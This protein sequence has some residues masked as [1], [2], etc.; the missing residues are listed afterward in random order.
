M[1]RLKVGMWV[2][3][4]GVMRVVQAWVGPH[5]PPLPPPGGMREG[6]ANP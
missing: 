6:E 4:F 3:M 2:A 5:K 1:G